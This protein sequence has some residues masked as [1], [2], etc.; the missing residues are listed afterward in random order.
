MTKILLILVIAFTFEAF[1]VITLKRGLD[2]IGPRFTERKATL[3]TW[4]N[5][6]RLVGDWFTTK[7]VLL[8]L[9]LETAFFVMLQYLL[10]QRDV[11][12]IW[13]LTAM[14]FVMTTLAAQF[15]LGER[16]N[17]FRWG[18]V[19]LIV[20]GAALI[21][22]GEHNKPKELPPPAEGAPALVK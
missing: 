11:S 6:L 3:P 16:V 19:V 15:I 20:L 7:D 17:A 21:T 18:G 5:V 4:K 12:F 22:Y 14:S 1:G 8:G 10:G 13:P 9:L 2:Q